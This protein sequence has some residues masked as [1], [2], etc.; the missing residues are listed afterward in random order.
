MAS[1]LT[2]KRQPPAAIAGLHVIMR[3]LAVPFAG[4]LGEALPRRVIDPH[5]RHVADAVALGRGPLAPVAVLGHADAG[6]GA[7]IAQTARRTTRLPV[8]V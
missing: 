4:K 8:P 6:E 7:D 2:A 5:L 3:S 1:V